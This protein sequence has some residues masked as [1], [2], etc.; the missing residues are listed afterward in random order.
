[1][2]VFIMCLYVFLNGYLYTIIILKKKKQTNKSNL[3]K[4]RQEKLKPPS[5]NVI[6]IQY[7]IPIIVLC[8]NYI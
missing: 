4:L 1:M 5:V 2:N 3:N 7:N 6:T 8:I